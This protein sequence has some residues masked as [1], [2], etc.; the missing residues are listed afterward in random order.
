MMIIISM[1]LLLTVCFGCLATDLN[2]LRVIQTPTNINLSAGDSTEITCIWE[3]A[4]KRYRACWY[5]VNKVNITKSISSK[6]LYSPNITCENK[7]VL[8]IKSANVNDTGFYY[9]EIIIEIPFFKKLRG[10]GTT[11]IVEEKAHSLERRYLEAWAILPFLA[12]VGSLCLC[13]KKKKHS[14]LSGAAQL[15]V[16]TARQEQEQEQRLEEEELH[17]RNESTREAAEENSSSN[18][19]EWVPLCAEYG[20]SEHRQQTPIAACCVFA[21]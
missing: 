20:S 18:S 6:V 19:A 14:T 15:P 3:K 2:N 5:F 8:V 16:L 4:V 21:L 13:Y 10:N 7:D 12:A 1:K 9:C 17:G 11:V